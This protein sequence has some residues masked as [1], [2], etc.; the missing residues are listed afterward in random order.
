[1]SRRLVDFDPL[2]GIAHYSEW[3]ELDDALRFTAVQDAD[4]IVAANQAEAA[5]NRPFGELAKVASIPLPLFQTLWQQG[6]IQDKKKFMR[7]CRDPDN[8]MFLTRSG[9]I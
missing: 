3:G 8:R 9:K 6:V 5:E 2:T 1:M 4:A 7:W